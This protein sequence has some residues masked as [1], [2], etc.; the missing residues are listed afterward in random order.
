MK[1]KTASL[2]LGA[3]LIIYLLNP[4][5]KDA[6]V[7]NPGN[8]PEKA[9]KGTIDAVVQGNYAPNLGRIAFGPE[10]A[11][12]DC[13]AITNEIEV[14]IDK[15]PKAEVSLNAAY[16]PNGYDKPPTCS[17]GLMD[18]DPYALN[19]GNLISFR[20]LYN[21]GIV[22]CSTLLEL[23]RKADGSIDLLNGSVAGGDASLTRKKYTENFVEQ[24]LVFIP[25]T[26]GYQVIEIYFGGKYD[27][28]NVSYIR[29]QDPIF[30]FQLFGN[31]NLHIDKTSDIESR[32]NGRDP[33]PPL[34]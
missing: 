27:G 31:P 33:T 30:R 26:I 24:E 1:G 3:A 17:S 4:V 19:K 10:E 29:R 2:G 25:D 28:N 12:A 5:K 22:P 16:Y 14:F 18:D 8:Q 32:V 9:D 21:S 23:V 11:R 6:V 15:Y 7:L 34:K 13:T 20:E